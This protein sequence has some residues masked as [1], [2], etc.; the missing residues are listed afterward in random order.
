MGC[1]MGGHAARHGSPPGPRDNEMPSQG[2]PSDPVSNEPVPN[3]DAVA[4]VY[5][6]K[7]YRF[8]S[9]ENRDRFEAAPEQFA[10]ATAG[11]PL[12]QR[13]KGHGGC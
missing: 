4:T 13:H 2:P 12:P 5:R 1:G 9:R 8:A 7:V 6:G 3:E 11:D 10:K